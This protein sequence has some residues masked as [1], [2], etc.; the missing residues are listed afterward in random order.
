MGKIMSIIDFV[1]TFEEWF[2][3]ENYLALELKIS[4]IIL[5]KMLVEN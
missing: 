1:N 4:D 3:M 5:S 2:F